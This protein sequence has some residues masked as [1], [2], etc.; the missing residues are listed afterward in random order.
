MR[1][2][3]CGLSLRQVDLEVSSHDAI[4]LVKKCYW[5]KLKHCFNTLF[6]SLEFTA[7]FSINPIGLACFPFQMLDFNEI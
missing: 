5:T 2:Q 1:V 3:P 7:G 4:I 6:S